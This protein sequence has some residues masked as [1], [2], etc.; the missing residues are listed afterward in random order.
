MKLKFLPLPTPLS[1][2]HKRKID[3][4]EQI[5]SINCSI[6]ESSDAAVT[7]ILLPGDKTFSNSSST[8]I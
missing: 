3:P 6:S 4:S 5:K 2:L 1:Y 8:L 7:K